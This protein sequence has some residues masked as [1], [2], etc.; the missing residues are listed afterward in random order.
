MRGLGLTTTEQAELWAR[1]KR[2]ESLSDITRALGRVHYS[3]VAQ[4]VH[5][6]G[7]VVPA[8]RRRSLR[9]LSLAER[10][11]ISRGL[12]LDES[13]RAIGR[14]LQRAPSTISREVGRHG[15]PRAYR[16]GRAD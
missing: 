4:R 15:G 12:A 7:G 3:A 13:L 5:R 11:E 14:R 10:E 1:W 9:V 6:C 16:A 2:G 8:I